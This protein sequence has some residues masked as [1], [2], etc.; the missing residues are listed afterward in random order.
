LQ[1]DLITFFSSFL[2]ARAK[3]GVGAPSF[4]AALSDQPVKT[5]PPTLKL[6]IFLILARKAWDDST[7][8]VDDVECVAASL[9]D[10]GYVKAYAI[11][12]GGTIVFRRTPDFGFMKIS[13]VY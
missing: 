3:S 12:N 9:I 7:F 8:T 10:Q 11:H 4:N 2:V 13:S 6:A 1:S 5:P